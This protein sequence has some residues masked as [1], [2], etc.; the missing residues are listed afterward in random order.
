V[1]LLAVAR[2][3][4]WYTEGRIF[5]GEGFEDW[6]ALPDD[7]VLTVMLW[8]ANGTRRIEQ[9][10]DS[11]FATPEGIY[12]HSNET[13]AEIE[14]RYPGASVKRGKWTTDAEMDR[15]TTEAIGAE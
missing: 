14:P 12:G 4:A 5:D 3:R 8:F 15:V 6:Q 9:G 10:N 7:G 2:W 1:S 13:V 11:Y